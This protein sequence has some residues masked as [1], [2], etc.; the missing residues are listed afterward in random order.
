[1][2]EQVAAGFIKDKIL[3]KGFYIYTNRTLKTSYREKNILFFKTSEDKRKFIEDKCVKVNPIQRYE[4]V[5]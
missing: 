4:L 1:M 3:I 5:G 2:G